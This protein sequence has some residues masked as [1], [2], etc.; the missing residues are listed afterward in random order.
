MEILGKLLSDEV[1]S[2]LKLKPS[3]YK[4]VWTVLSKTFERELLAE[5][6]SAILK[7][8][9]V[10][11]PVKCFTNT[12]SVSCEEFK[13]IY[14]TAPNNI[15][16]YFHISLTSPPVFHCSLPLHL[17]SPQLRSPSFP[18][19][20]LWQSVLMSHYSVPNCHQVTVLYLFFKTK[21]SSSSM[22]RELVIQPK[23]WLP[24][25]SRQVWMIS[26]NESH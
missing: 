6:W 2:V 5:I 17:F 23:N 21:S 18:L 3:H 13:S 7:Y 25:Q 22:H 9:R 12:D 26:E 8:F 24:P 19:A 16:F 1:I 15:T 14:I 4:I 20:S 11:Y 10:E